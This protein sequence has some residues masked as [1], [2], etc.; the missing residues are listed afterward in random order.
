MKSEQ[1]IVPSGDAGGRQSIMT[2]VL[3]SSVTKEDGR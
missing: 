2:L 3:L 1:P